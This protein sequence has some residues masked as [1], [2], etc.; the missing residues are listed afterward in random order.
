MAGGATGAQ[1]APGPL[2]R[3]LGGSQP[4]DPQPGQGT[5][6]LER[7]ENE[8]DPRVEGG[9]PRRQREGI[10][11]QNGGGGHPKS[12]GV[13]LKSQEI[14]PKLRGRRLTSQNSVCV[15][16]CH[17][18]SQGVDTRTQSSSLRGDR[19]PLSPHKVCVGVS[20]RCPPRH[21]KGLPSVTPE[22]ASPPVSLSP[23]APMGSLPAPRV[24]TKG[25]SPGVPPSPAGPAA[26][27]SR[28]QRLRM[29]PRKRQPEA[30][31]RKR[32]LRAGRWRGRG[33]RALCGGG[34]VA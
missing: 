11:P 24:P 25:V 31:L 2:G 27:R 28:R 34:G 23:P 29:R 10:S 13:H 17:P 20:F 21:A 8:G 4:G 22:G 32:R 30:P 7:T 3:L 15:W 16:G 19:P 6:G 1:G 18:K 12:R 9:H 33:L 26:G 14:T 5:W